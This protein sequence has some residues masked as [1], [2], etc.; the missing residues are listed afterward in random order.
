MTTVTLVQ[1]PRLNVV[2]EPLHLQEAEVYRNRQA[3]G[4]AC[5]ILGP[6]RHAVEAAAAVS[7]V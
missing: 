3:A 1:A 6:H 4:V 7:E 2:A 5:P